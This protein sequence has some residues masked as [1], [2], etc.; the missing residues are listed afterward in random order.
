M[1]D[2]KRLRNFLKEMEFSISEGDKCSICPSC[3]RCQHEHFGRKG[4]RET[5]ELAAI[6]REV[7]Q[8]IEDRKDAIREAV[9]ER[10]ELREVLAPFALHGKALGL[11]QRQDNLAVVS[12]IGVSS[13]CIGA[14][15]SALEMFP[16]LLE[17]AKSEQ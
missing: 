1:V 10:D 7:E 2:L 9:V 13:L 12:K 16:E 15:R 4:H 17:S 3:Q 8:E 5:C 14:F 6:L 11:P